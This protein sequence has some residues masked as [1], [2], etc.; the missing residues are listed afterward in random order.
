MSPIL[1]E[2]NKREKNKEKRRNVYEEKININC[3]FS[4]ALSDWM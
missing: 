4:H 2:Y 1:F 3:S